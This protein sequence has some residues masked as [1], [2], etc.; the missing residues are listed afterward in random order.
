MTSFYGSSCAN[1]G[2]G[3]LNTPG[4]VC[5]RIKGISVVLSDMLE[6]EQCRFWEVNGV[7]PGIDS[8]AQLA[9]NIA[10]RID[11]P[12][13]VHPFG[14]LRT[15]GGPRLSKAFLWSGLLINNEQTLSEVGLRFREALKKTIWGLLPSCALCSAL[16]ETT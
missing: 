16:Y 15:K 14:Q 7:H 12:V 1:N 13:V 10:T 3:A 5:C 11:D 9:E 8:A 6:G 4:W 2:D